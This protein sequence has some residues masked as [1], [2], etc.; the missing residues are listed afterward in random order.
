M[1]EEVTYA[2]LSFQ[3]TDDV[4]K[5]PQMDLI[6]KPEQSAPLS[7]RR[8]VPPGQLTLC[9]LLLLLLLLLLSGLV[10]LGILFSQEQAERKN[11]HSR[12]TNLTQS[13]QRM[14]TELCRQLVAGNTESKCS[15]CEKGWQ[16]SGDSC[17]RKFDIWNTWPKGKKFC[18]DNNSTLVKVDSREELNFISAFKDVWLG[19]S[20]NVSRRSWLWEDGSALRGDL[21]SITEPYSDHGINFCA[22]QQN[23]VRSAD[24]LD[25]KYFLC[26]TVAGPVRAESLY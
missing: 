14:T 26:E 9:L 16:W 3:R 11:L 13:L 7:V 4:E 25:Y 22:F 12:N 10:V 20:F 1:K 17:Y 23:H 5:V 24:C 2:D 18:H 19:L 8:S 15:P 6:E 21:I